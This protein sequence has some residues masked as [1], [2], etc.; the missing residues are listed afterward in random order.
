MIFKMV[1]DYQNDNFILKIALQDC[2]SADP[3]YLL[4]NNIRFPEITFTE[5]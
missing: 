3:Q 2:S 5:E 4:C 1:N